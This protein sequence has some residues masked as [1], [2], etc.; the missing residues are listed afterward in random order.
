MEDVLLL[1]GLCLI[2]GV[3]AVAY[4]RKCKL[5]GETWDY[6]GGGMLGLAIVLWLNVLIYHLINGGAK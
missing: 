3:D 5:L 4:G 6:V 1:V 2:A